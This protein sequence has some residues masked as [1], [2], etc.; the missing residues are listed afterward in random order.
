MYIPH[1]VY[2]FIHQ[3][4]LDCFH[5]LA[6]V[7]NVAMNIKM[8]IQIPLQV[9]AVNSFKYIPR[10]GIAISYSKSIFNF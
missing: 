3:L 2:L 10:S 4:T 5:F 8:G 6:A 9:S 1:S 7:D